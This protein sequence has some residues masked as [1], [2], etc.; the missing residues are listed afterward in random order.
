VHPFHRT[1][2]V[3]GPD[4]LR[5]V[6]GGATLLD[7]REAFEW[8]AGHAPEAVHV[9][10]MQLQQPP[11]SLAPG[12]EVVVV[13]RSGNRSRTA[14]DHLRSLGYEAVNL[15]GGM[16]AWVQAGGRIVDGSGGVGTVA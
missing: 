5:R 7:V 2:D 9:P 16:P 11:A 10:L 8:D 13:C 1:P 12:S 4:A 3:D 15:A 6:A 14:T